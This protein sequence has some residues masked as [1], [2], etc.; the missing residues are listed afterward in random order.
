MMNWFTVKSNQRELGMRAQK[1][2]ERA[3][4]R[5]G[6]TPSQIFLNIVE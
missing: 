2:E 5:I 1:F 3:T 4:T 6:H